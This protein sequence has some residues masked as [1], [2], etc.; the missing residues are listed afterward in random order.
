MKTEY[1]KYG[2][3]KGDYWADWIGLKKTSVTVT[4]NTDEQ[5][6]IVHSRYVETDK[7]GNENLIYTQVTYTHTATVNI[8]CSVDKV[9]QKTDYIEQNANGETL[10]KNSNTSQYDITDKKAD[11]AP[12]KDFTTTVKAVSK[13]R[14]SESKSGAQDYLEKLNKGN[15]HAGLAG[16]ILG[17]G[18]T[19]ATYTALNNVA[20]KAIVSN[21]SAK[22]ALQAVGLTSRQAYIV[23]K[24]AEIKN[25][26]KQV[27]KGIK[28]ITNKS[29]ENTANAAT[30]NTVDKYKEKTNR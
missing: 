23:T 3:N 29:V 12:L 2:Q 8:D 30:K 5:R 6:N 1:V 11:A 16:T 27:S 19:V 15:T 13:H 9:Q 26:S 18:T 24:K 10:K 28:N 25:I 17:V 4:I 22:K 20:N 7:D 21:P 14:Q